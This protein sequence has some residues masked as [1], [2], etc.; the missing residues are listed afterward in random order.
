MNC[1]IS[2]WDQFWR[3]GFFS[4]F[5][6]DVLVKEVRILLLVQIGAYPFVHPFGFQC[7]CPNADGITVHS[8][9]GAKITLELDAGI[10]EGLMNDGENSF[11]VG[12]GSDFWN[13]ATVRFE[14][15]NLRN[16]DVA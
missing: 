16:D 4:L 10:F 13:D 3:Y 9:Q 7:L 2:G 5:A 8:F 12:T 1:E 15:I 11:E 14:N 6:E